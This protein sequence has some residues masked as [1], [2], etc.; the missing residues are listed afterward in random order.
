MLLYYSGPFTAAQS[1]WHPFEQEL[2]GLLNLKR[3]YV[4]HFGRIA[5][6]M[7]TDHGTITRLEYL[8]LDRIDAKHYRWYAELTQSGDLLLYNPGTS[9]LHKV[10]D[11]LSRE[12]ELR[13][14]L[15]LARIGEWT[16]VREQIRGVQAGIDSGEY[17][18]EEPAAFDKKTLQVKGSLPPQEKSCSWND[19]KRS[20]LPRNSRRLAKE[21][22]HLG[23]AQPRFKPC[24]LA[25]FRSSVSSISHPGL[26]SLRR[27][28]SNY[29]H[30]PVKPRL[31]GR[32]YQIQM[33]LSQALA[34]VLRRF[35]GSRR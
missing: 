1:Q 11:G 28:R 30:L 15:N 16:Q 4:K 8:P 23:D 21:G 10:F 35:Q 27:S 7:H 13:D 12:T 34:T 29:S 24:P 22:P 32:L 5:I 14:D 3:D 25:S 33:W 9:Q 2:Y 31:L 26:P 17:D 18:A 19:E 20:K 6:V